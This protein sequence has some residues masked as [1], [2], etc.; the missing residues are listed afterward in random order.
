MH[1][2]ELAVS[3]GITQLAP[4]CL[5]QAMGGSMVEAGRFHHFSAYPLVLVPTV[6]NYPTGREEDWILWIL[7]FTW[8]SR[9]LAMNGGSW[10]R[11]SVT[12]RIV[13]GC[14]SFS[15][16]QISLE[17]YERSWT[18]P[19]YPKMTCGETGSISVT[20][21]HCRFMICMN[22][23][24]WSEENKQ[25]QKFSNSMQL[26]FLF[27]TRVPGHLRNLVLLWPF[28][29][30]QPMCRQC[31][32]DQCGCGACGPP[33]HSDHGEAVSQ[34]SQRYVWRFPGGC[35]LALQAA[36]MD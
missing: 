28:E 24:A 7:S 9:A 20:L 29:A 1:H 8:F 17:I 26:D 23:V 30:P 19:K 11:S 21:L 6:H 33:S 3:Q 22:N 32:Q 34:L 18:A 25:S 5:V 12:P 35:R 14:R 27:T 15:S 31:S 10:Y 13:L 2:R 4:H 16:R 36:C